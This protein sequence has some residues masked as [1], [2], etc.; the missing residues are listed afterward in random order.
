MLDDMPE[1]IMTIIVGLIILSV[2]VFVV[3]T[4]VG[5]TDTAD[6]YM[7]HFAVSDPAVAQSFGLKSTPNVEPVVEQW[8]GVSWST[9]NAVYVNYT[10]SSVTIELEGIYS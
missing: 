9:I 7:E 4:I 10:S 1:I 6:S 3:G 2:G 8:N 5:E